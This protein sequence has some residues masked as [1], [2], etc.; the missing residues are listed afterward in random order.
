MSTYGEPI[1]YGVGGTYVET[2]TAIV[3]PTQKTVTADPYAVATAYG[4]L[5]S[6]VDSAVS[7]AVYS[8]ENI[9]TFSEEVSIGITPASDLLAFSE[10]ANIVHD[11]S[12]SLT[13]SEPMYS[14][15]VDTLAFSDSAD[16]V[17]NVVDTLTFSETVERLHGVAEDTLTFTETVSYTRNQH[18]VLAFSE[19]A[20]IIT[21]AD[22]S[23]TFSETAGIIFAASND[24][25]FSE[26]LIAELPLTDQLTWLETVTHGTHLVTPEL[27]SFE[28]EATWNRVKSV[29]ED[30]LLSFYEVGRYTT[31]H[32][33][34]VT[35]SGGTG[36]ALPTPSEEVVGTLT[37]GTH[38]FRVADSYDLETEFGNGTY[39]NAGSKYSLQL[40]RPL[41]LV[42]DWQLELRALV[43][44]KQLVTNLLPSPFEAFITDETS[45]DSEGISLVFYS[46]DHDT[47]GAT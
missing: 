47:R 1:P 10:V 45:L 42:G 24:I 35:G 39:L 29:A 38:S 22:E 7:D 3:E 28:Q 20:A 14:R 18:D 41:D 21:A 6:Y 8:A 27:L 2:P 46:L 26:P 17:R 19:T 30:H 40:G 13:F 15:G 12:N 9:L 16:Y 23:L 25:S 32:D 36:H 11:A 43:G 5:V 4:E 44:T 34:I 37:V 33:G 31:L